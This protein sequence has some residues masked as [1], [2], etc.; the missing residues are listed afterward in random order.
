VAVP[1]QTLADFVSKVQPFLAQ[2]I[3]PTTKEVSPVSADL[4]PRFVPPPDH[5]PKFVP[6]RADG[7]Q[8]RPEE[9]YEVSVLRK[10]AQLL[11][12]SM[13]NFI[14]VQSF[15]W[16]SGDKEPAAQAEYEVRIIDGVQRFRRYPDGKSELEEVPYPRVNG[17]VN[18]ADEWSKVPNMVGTEFRLKVHQAADVVVNEQRMK[19]FQYYANVEDNLYPFAPVE[20][21]G[22]FTISKTVAVACYGEVWT[23]EDANIIRMSE[24]LELSDKLKA[25][26]G[27][28]DCQV[29]LTYG[30]LNREN[31]PP[32]LVPLT[33]FA[34]ARYKKHVHWCRGQFRD[35]QIFSTRARI[36]ASSQP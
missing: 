1:V 3:F 21:F 19:V 28:E 30:W 29:V 18:P 20:D 12:D 16:G 6:R 15:A 35:Y 22:F 32:R 23:D 11:A 36:I 5:Y 33:I 7:L 31:D 24:H 34:V 8:H 14:A 17:W 9:P 27:W 26:R 2:R 4:Y 13:R 10:K 25:Y